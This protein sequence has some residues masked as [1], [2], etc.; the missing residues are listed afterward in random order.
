MAFAEV[1]KRGLWVVFTFLGTLR[2]LISVH[3]LVHVHTTTHQNCDDY[4]DDHHRQTSLV[5]V[6]IASTID[7]L[8]SSLPEPVRQTLLFYTNTLRLP[9]SHF[10][11]SPVPC[12]PSHLPSVILLHKSTVLDPPCRLPSP[13]T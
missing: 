9:P 2:I 3:N 13:P 12:S 1:A 8:P 7:R 6:N 11:L 10:L 4:D 5:S